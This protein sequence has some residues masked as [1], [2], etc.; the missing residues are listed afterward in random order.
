MT[1]RRG[2][3]IHSKTEDNSLPMRLERSLRS[4]ALSKANTAAASSILPKFLRTVNA[5]KTNPFLEPTSPR[6]RHVHT[7]KTWEAKARVMI[8]LESLTR[9]CQGPAAAAQQLAVDFPQVIDA[10]AGAK[11]KD[12][13]PRGLSNVLLGWRREFSRSN[14]VLDSVAAELYAEGIKR[15]DELHAAVEIPGLVRFAALTWRKFN[16]FCVFI[17]ANIHKSFS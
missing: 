15:I 6:A 8:A 4:S 2:S 12:S 3:L 5:V 13:G 9:T 16:G 1:E 10:L 11:A 14:G 17:R 7:S